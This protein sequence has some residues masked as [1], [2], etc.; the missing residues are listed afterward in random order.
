MRNGISGIDSNESIQC[1]ARLFIIGREGARSSHRFSRPNVNSS[2]DNE[3]HSQNGKSYPYGL[4]NTEGE[5]V[6]SECIID[7]TNRSNLF[8]K[9]EG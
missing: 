2:S 9:R 4:A 7:I 5:V 6:I 3:T 8:M 1:F